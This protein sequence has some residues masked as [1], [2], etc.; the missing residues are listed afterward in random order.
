MTTLTN[1]RVALC[2]AVDVDR[3]HPG[4]GDRVGRIDGAA[5]RLE[6]ARR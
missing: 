3:P 1:R 6:R 4:V 2:R 5:D